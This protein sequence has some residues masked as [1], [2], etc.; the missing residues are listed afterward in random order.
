MI[1]LQYFFKIINVIYLILN[2]LVFRE[3]INL[4]LNNFTVNLY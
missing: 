3:N 1:L 2:F 4:I